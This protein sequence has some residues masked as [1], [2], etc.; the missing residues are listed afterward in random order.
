MKLFLLSLFLVFA[1]SA[2]AGNYSIGIDY[3]CL[4]L[5]GTPIAKG[6]D[7]AAKCCV[8]SPGPECRTGF[9][10]MVPAAAED[11]KGYLDVARAGI[12]NAAVLNGIDLDHR[13]PDQATTL[14]KVASPSNAAALIS[15][16]P[17]NPE[18]Q[19]SMGGAQGARSSGP[20]SGVGAGSGY[21]GGMVGMKTIGEG[22][23]TRETGAKTAQEFGGGKYLGGSGDSSK[24]GAEGQTAGVSIGDVSELKF[25]AAGETHGKG[26]G[27]LNPDGSDSEGMSGSREDSPDYLNRIDKAASIFKIVSKRYEKELARNR[28]RLPELK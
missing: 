22:S 13:D 3:A 2:R 12:K 1:T 27:N 11:T 7:L 10:T 4:S 5:D 20:L 23:R 26:S 21:P 24:S 18:I 25:G 6:S 17:G 14:S 16:S 28:L 9:S 19:F 8:A 15:D